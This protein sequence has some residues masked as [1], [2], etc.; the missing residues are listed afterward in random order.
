MRRIAAAGSLFLFALLILAACGGSET[1]ATLEPIEIAP[2]TEAPADTSSS[3][4]DNSSAAAEISSSAAIF[5]I[6]QGQS[7]VRFQLDED[8]RGARKTVIGETNQVAGEIL[9]D[10]ADLAAAQVG[11][12]Q[13][14][15][16]SLTTDSNF[17]NK[18]INEF[19][20]QTDKFPTITF[21]PTGIEGLPATAAVGDELSFVIN[22]DLT[23]RDITVP[24][25]WQVTAK[26]VS[27]SQISGTATTTVTRAD[28]ELKIPS[29]PNVANVDDAVQL[30]IAFVANGS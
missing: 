18:A 2:A 30:T 5:T 29:V 19:I 6:D 24:T 14:G 9:F 22:G 21:A 15:A 1:P 27:A 28:Y 26:A 16:G 11:I 10:L 7:S 4:A 17:R 13:I 25:S 23:I 12:I 8:L 20:L 3:S